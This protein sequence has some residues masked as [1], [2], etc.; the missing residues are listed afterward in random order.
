MTEGQ[1]KFE[2]RVVARQQ[3]TL[4][5]AVEFMAEQDQPTSRV[6]GWTRDLS[7]RGAF[8][9]S[10]AAFEAGQR[11]RLILQVESDS[12]YK[13]YTEIRWEAEVIRVEP[14]ARERGVAVR[15]LQFDIPKVVT[16]PVA[17]PN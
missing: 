12:V 11:L 17:L 3:M 10:P 4:P 9:W 14:R 5:I 7:S 6:T 16:C 2:R 1:G 8:F 15:I 13:G